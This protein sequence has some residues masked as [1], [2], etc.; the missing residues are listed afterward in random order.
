M[1]VVGEVGHIRPTRKS[2]LSITFRLQRAATCPAET[3]VMAF[4]PSSVNSSSSTADRAARPVLYKSRGAHGMA[5]AARR[6]RRSGR[7][8]RIEVSSIEDGGPLLAAYGHETVWRRR[9]IATNNGPSSTAKA[10]TQPRGSRALAPDRAPRSRRPRAA[11]LGRE[12]R[13][14]RLRSLRRP[15]WLQWR[16]RYGEAALPHPAAAC[17]FSSPRSNRLPAPRH[18]AIERNR[19]HGCGRLPA[20]NHEH[21]IYLAQ[22]RGAVVRGNRIYANAD[23]GIQLYPD[24]RGSRIV[25]NVIDGNGQGIAISGAGGQ[26]SSG[27]LIR[28][29]VITNSTLRYNVYSDFPR[30]VGKH[31][32]VRFNCVYGGAAAR[33]GGAGGIM[34]PTRGF[35]LEGN[36]IAD[37]GYGNRSAGDFRLAAHSPCRSLGKRIALRSVSR[38]SR[39]RLPLRLAGRIPAP[40]TGPV[41]RARLEVKRRGGWTVARRMTTRSSAFA[42]RVRPQIAKGRR[43]VAIRVAAPGRAPSK[44]IWVVRQR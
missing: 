25:H 18:V 16:A 1:R 41:K 20:T 3:P 22:S 34:R 17:R 6:S 12:L 5:R 29:N 31:N 2:L 39:R 30:R 15:P 11:G 38:R 13:A 7:C 33:A 43:G 35:R 10:D 19:I 40:V 42:M 23:R 9:A 21:G 8:P 44:P 4:P 28:A 26:A 27:N 32:F 37:P 14:P 36:L 24:A